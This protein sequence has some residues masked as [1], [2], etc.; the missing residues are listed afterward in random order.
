MDII[1][2]SRV[3]QYVNKTT[4]QIV[5]YRVYEVVIPSLPI[6]ISVSPSDKTG[7]QILQSYF[8][9]LEKGGK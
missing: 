8:E 9:K 3:D 4:N 2:T 1:L 7:R 6:A 5:N